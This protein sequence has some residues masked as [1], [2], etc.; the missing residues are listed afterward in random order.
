MGAFA[1][2]AGSYEQ[3]AQARSIN[4]PTAMEG[5]EYMERKG[6]SPFTPPRTPASPKS[7]SAFFPGMDR[8]HL[9]SGPADQPGQVPPPPAAQP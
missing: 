9:N 5:N 2:G 1:A 7:M 8:S 4:V 3:T 6:T